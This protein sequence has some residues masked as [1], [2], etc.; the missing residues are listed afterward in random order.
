MA[1]LEDVFFYGARS[2]SKEY[3][4][5]WAMSRV[6]VAIYRQG[7]Y[8]DRLVGNEQGDCCNIQTGAICRQVLSTDWWRV[9]VTG[10]VYW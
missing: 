2:R 1:A 8:V 10:D 6:T 3:T 4:G 7:Q 9:L 5:E